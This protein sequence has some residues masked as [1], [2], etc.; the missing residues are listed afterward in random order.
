MNYE[1]S[2]ETILEFLQ[3]E[4]VFSLHDKLW[5]GIFQNCINAA[6]T[7]EALSKRVGEVIVKSEAINFQQDNIDTLQAFL[8]RLHFKTH[9]IQAAILACKN[10]ETLSS[11]QSIILNQALQ[12]LK[13]HDAYYRQQLDSICVDDSVFAASGFRSSLLRDNQGWQV[14]RMHCLGVYK[15][16]R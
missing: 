2:H 12:W 6:N 16:N 1:L 11:H 3:L 14:I 4:K 7:I 8:A 15:I 10:Q 5:L 13:E 9:S